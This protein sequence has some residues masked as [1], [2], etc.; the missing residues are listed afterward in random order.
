MSQPQT[1]LTIGKTPIK[2]KA[3][4]IYLTAYP[5]QKTAQELMSGFENGFRLHYTGPPHSKEYKNLK[6]AVQLPNI[7]NEKLSNEIS[8]GRMAGPFAKIPIDNLRCSPVGLVPKKSPG[9]YRL[10]HHLSYPIGESVN[11]FIAPELRSVNYTAFDEAITL[12]QSIGPNVFLAKAD[13]K[14]AF[15]LLPV[16]PLDFVQLGIKFN[17]SYYIDKCMPFGC[18]IACATFEKFATF[19]EWAVSRQLNRVH[20]GILHYLDDFLFVGSSF[21]RCQEILRIFHSV[22]TDLAI[23]IAH[24]KS[25]G[26]V[27][28]LTFLGLTVDVPRREVRIPQAKV[29]E[30]MDKLTQFASHSKQTLRAFQS[31]IGSLNFACKAITPGR[32]FIR[33]LID[34]TSNVSQSHHHIRVTACIKQDLAMWQRFFTNHNGVTMFKDINWTSTDKLQLYSDSAGGQGRGFGVYFNG[35]WCNGS[36]PDSW[37]IAGITSDITFLEFFPILVAVFTWPHQLRN[38]KVIFRSDNQAVVHIINKLSTTSKNTMYLV[39]EFTLQCMRLNML[40][41]AEHIPGLKN[42]ICDALSR[43]QLQ[44]F[45]RLAPEAAQYPTDV[46]SAVWEVI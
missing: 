27:R 3:L 25:E 30:I 28:C 43:F 4:K 35:Q 44:R 9:E 16:S 13:I 14:S 24:D 7:V 5:Y 21:D 32:P 37:H 41:K 22:C 36:W 29:H 8:L 40:A 19:I 23:P 1:R 18:A 11:D 12:I 39:R 42:E 34:A 20:H 31:L 26:P 10:I 17:G 6:S 38:R 33:R 45:R 46:P 2:I 15:R